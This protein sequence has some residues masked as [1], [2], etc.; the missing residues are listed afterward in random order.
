[1]T[2]PKPRERGSRGGARA[3]LPHASFGGVVWTGDGSR[4]GVVWRGEEKR[5]ES[6]AVRGRMGRT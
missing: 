1:M 3:V 4:G 5:C 6:E 2:Q